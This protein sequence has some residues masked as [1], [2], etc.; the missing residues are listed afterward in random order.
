MKE[1]Y[2]VSLRKKEVYP[3]GEYPFTI[4][5]VREFDEINFHPQVTFFVGENGSGKSTLLEALAKSFSL[6]AEG[7]SRNMHFSTEET[8]S[9]LDSYLIVKKGIIRARDSYFLRAESYYNVATEIRKLDDAPGDTSS[10]IIDSYGGLSLHHQSHGESFFSLL[11]HRLHGNGIYLLDE[12]EA[13]L[14]V[15]RQMSMIARMH[16]LCTKEK[17]Q[18][19]IATHSPILLSYPH[20]WIYEFSEKGIVRRARDEVENFSLMQ[21]FMRCPERYVKE[22][23][24]KE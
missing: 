22:L 19:I 6:N 9:S 14:S 16:E 2:L 10:R 7:G 5:A 1:Q 20:A 15:R 24:E 12:P 4:P 21:D 11:H 3:D 23:L 18:F 8:T 13:A 17:S